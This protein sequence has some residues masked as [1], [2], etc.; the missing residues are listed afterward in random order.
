VV[1]NKFFGNFEIS[2]GISG[3]SFS[4]LMFVATFLISFVSWNVDT[5]ITSCGSR[6]ADFSVV[7]WK[8]TGKTVVNESMEKFCYFN[9]RNC[10]SWSL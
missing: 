4:F 9:S 5:R 1:T 8:G 2:G 3:Y 7:I 10:T 6:W